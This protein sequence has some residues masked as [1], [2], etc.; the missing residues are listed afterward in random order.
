MMAEMDK[1]QAE[2]GFWEKVFLHHLQQ[3]LV[4]LVGFLQIIKMQILRF[5]LLL[6]LLLFLQYYSL[7]WH[8][9]KYRQ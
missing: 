7:L 3:C 2:L 1:K 6:A 4:W 8:T 9:E 5:Y